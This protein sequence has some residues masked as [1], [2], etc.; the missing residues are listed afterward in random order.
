MTI[1]Q[2]RAIALAALPRMFRADE[3]VHVHCLRKVNGEIRPEGVSQ[4]YTAMT[5]IGLATENAHD[6]RMALSGASPA[7]VCDA[8][9]R[10][11]DGWTN[12]GD[13]AVTLWAA[14]LLGCA[15]ADRALRR[16]KTLDPVNKPHPTVE[17]AWTIAALTVGGDASPD[18]TLAH[19]TAKRLLESY[20]TDA[21]LFPHQPNDAPAPLLRG[22]VGCFAD[23]V[24]PIQALAFYGMKF[25][26]T[27]A[28]NTSRGCARKICELMG[29]AG[30]WWWHY[31]VRSG[32]VVEGYP[33]Y[34][35]HQDAMAPMALLAA[36]A[37]CGEN[38]DE[39]IE[40]GL[41]W[42]VRSPEIG[43]SLIDTDNQ[44]I[45]RKVCRKEPG[46]LTRAMQAVAS[47]IHPAVRVPGVGLAF[48]PV[49]IDWESRPYHMG[50]LLHAFPAS[51]SKRFLQLTTETSHDSARRVL[52]KPAS[53]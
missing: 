6:A 37:A 49:E 18:A 31:D 46:K 41:Q 10:R 7:D 40:L 22:H 43:G 8:L 39:A 26:D 1:D 3:N 51:M 32:R 9:I 17:L 30:Q 19:A 16:L 15:D 12:L 44:I 53:V 29:R 13:T 21:R 38:F 35:V 50:W 5:L 42:L 33:V 11:V 28:I 47:S 36:E 20:R 52:A 25:S 2:L 34:S 24:Y 45:W 14:R 23:Q 4:R 27:R 48:P